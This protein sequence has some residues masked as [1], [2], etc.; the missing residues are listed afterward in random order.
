MTKKNV[1]SQLQLVAQQNHL[2]Q[3]VAAQPA[4]IA[5]KT[6]SVI[7]QINVARIVNVNWFD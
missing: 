5:M 2:T 4:V 7:A 1:A 6:V 3:L